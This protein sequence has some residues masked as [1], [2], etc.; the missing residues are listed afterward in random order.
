MRRLKLLAA[1]L[2]VCV[3]APALA[4]STDPSEAAFR[5]LYK[6]LVETNTVP[7]HGRQLHQGR[8]SGVRAPEGRRLYR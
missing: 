1:S 5:S 7:T 6:D 2:L 3:A 4:Q 8:Q